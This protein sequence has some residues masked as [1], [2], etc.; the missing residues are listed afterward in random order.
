LIVNAEHTI[1]ARF[2]MDFLKKKPK[3]LV[4]SEIGCT[5]AAAMGH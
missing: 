2:F 4:G 3:N 1:T 5:F